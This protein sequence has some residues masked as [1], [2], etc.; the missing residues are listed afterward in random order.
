MT[1]QKDVVCERTEILNNYSRCDGCVKEHV[2]TDQNR[3]TVL[4]IRCRVIKHVIS[5]DQ[6]I[7]ILQ[8]VSIVDDIL[9]HYNVVA[10]RRR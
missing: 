6:I 5:D 10:T 8:I 2:V 4:K 1:I 3:V 7:A 9:L